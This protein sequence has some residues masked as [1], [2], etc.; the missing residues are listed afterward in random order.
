M[1][2]I[3]PKMWLLNQKMKKTFLFSAI[4]I[5]GILFAQCNV[6]TTAPLDGLKNHS[7]AQLLWD[8]TKSRLYS[9]GV[10]GYYIFVNNLTGDDNKS[11]GANA[12]VI[13]HVMIKYQNDDIPNK[14]TLILPSGIIEKTATNISYNTYNMFEKADSGTKTVECDFLFTTEEIRRIMNDNKFYGIK[15]ENYKNGKLILMINEADLYSGQLSEMFKCVNFIS[16]N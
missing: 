15:I 1:A 11:L 7:M 3:S 10:D 13:S 4:F 2:A 8:S 9:E 12:I 14:L 6:K 5:G 16:L